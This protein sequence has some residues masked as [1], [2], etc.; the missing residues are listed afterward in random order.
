MISSSIILPLKPSAFANHNIN[1]YLICL[2]PFLTFLLPSSFFQ[3]DARFAR[4]VNTGEIEVRF[5]PPLSL[6][7]LPLEPSLLVLIA[8]VPRSL[9]I[10]G[11]CSSPF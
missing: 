1:Q 2:S 11:F 10:A 6:L 7:C 8:Q 5:D 3:W 9:A 4:L